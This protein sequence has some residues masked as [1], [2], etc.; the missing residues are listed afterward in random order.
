MNVVST[1][2]SSSTQEQANFILH[3]Y[4]RM[5][6]SEADKMTNMFVQK[7]EKGRRQII[8]GSMPCGE[9]RG[10]ENYQTARS[11]WAG[12]LNVEDPSWG[13]WSLIGAMTQRRSTNFWHS[14]ALR[15]PCILLIFSVRLPGYMQCR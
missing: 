6:G 10:K 2:G 12:P 7:K 1:Y 11:A 14:S 15:C 3:I 9:M 13:V 5:Q 4:C 8:N